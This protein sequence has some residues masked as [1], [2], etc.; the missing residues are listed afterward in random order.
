MSFDPTFYGRDLKVS[1]YQD[2]SATAVR[3]Y[4]VDYDCG[5]I[6]SHFIPVSSGVLET[7]TGYTEQ[8]L[9][10]TDV[11]TF[12]ENQT[13]SPTGIAS[14]SVPVS[15]HTQHASGAWSEGV[16]IATATAL[17]PAPALTA[18]PLVTATFDGVDIRIIEPTD[19]DL[20]GYRV[21]MGTSAGFTPSGTGVPGNGTCV[22]DGSNAAF[23]VA[24]PDNAIRF[25]KIETKDAFGYADVYYT[26]TTVTGSKLNFD[27]AVAETPAITDL[28]TVYGDTVSAAASAAEAADSAAD[29]IAAEAAAIIAQGNATTAASTAT[30]QAGNASVS[31]T[32]AATS[33]T[34]ASGSATTATTQAGL[35]AGSA[36]AAG[37]SATAASTSAGA[38]STSATNASNS[39]TAA[40]S[41]SVSAASSYATARDRVASQFPQVITADLFTAT[42][43]GDP[44]STTNITVTT[45]AAYGPV[46][47]STAGGA[48]LATRGVVEALAGRVY[49]VRSTI[50][51]TTVPG[52]QSPTAIVAVRSLTAAYANVG[53]AQAPSG[54]AGYSTGSTSGTVVTLTRR[55]GSTAPTGG[56]AWN[57]P[58]STIWLRPYVTLNGSGSSTVRVR[59]ITIEDVTDVVASETQASAAATSASNASTSASEAGSSATAASS[60][61]T[62]ASTSAGAASTSASNAASSATTASGHASTA[63]TQAGLAATSATNAGNSATAANTSAGNAST[64]AT[65]AGNSATAAAASSVASSS[66][67]TS[68]RNT[69]A[70]VYPARPDATGTM[71]T[72][73]F[74]GS[75]ESV[76]L[77]TA[78][79]IVSYAGGGYVFQAP[80]VA[81]L[82]MTRGVSPATSSRT[83]KVTAEVLQTVDGGSA[84]VGRLVMRGLDGTYASL[85]AAVGPWVSTPQ[86][87]VTT[88]TYRFAASAT[89]GTTAWTAGSVWLRAYAQANYKSSDLLFNGAGTLQIISLTVDDITDLVAS[90]VQATAAATSATAAATSASAASTSSSAAGSSATAASGSATTASTHASTAGTHATNSSTSATGAAGSA[91]A[92]A[93]SATTAG[94]HA[95]TAG[96]HATT[97]STQASNASASAASASSS[98]SIAASVGHRA[99]NPN[100]GFD[101]YTTASGVPSNWSLWNGS[102]AA[103]AMDRVSDGAGGYAIMLT[104]SASAEHGLQQLTDVGTI[105]ASTYY[106]CE[107]EAEL[108][109]GA[110]TGGGV[111]LNTYNAATST[112]YENLYMSLATVPDASGVTSSSK[113]GRRAWSKLFLSTSNTSVSRAYIYAMSH[114]TGHGVITSANAITFYKCV[115]RP[116]T[117]QEVAAGVALPAL[118]ASVTTTQTT[119][120]T[121]DTSYALARYTLAATTGGGAAILT[122]ASDTYGTVAGI[123]ASKI[124]FGDNTFFDDATDTMRT[125]IGANVRVIAYGAAFGTDSTLTS[126]EGP[127]ATAFA[128]MSRAN[129]YFYTANA[130]P[131]AGGSALAGGQ[132][133][134][135]KT[136]AGTNGSTTGST[137][138][139]ADVVTGSQV[140][141]SFDFSVAY[142]DA[143]STMYGDVLL[144]EGSGGTWATL[145]TVSVG[146]GSSGLEY[147]GG[148]AA[149][150][151]GGSHVAIG[152]RSGSVTYRATFTR[153]SG[154]N[155]HGG[156]YQMSGS[157]SITPPLP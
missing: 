144:E 148:Y 53:G 156:T 37:G 87:T 80:G 123:A 44:A 107:I 57:T 90:E 150:S 103:G 98:A 26:G 109:S 111:Y 49:E 122:L 60:S 61:A 33:A 132:T 78:S 149:E 9:C 129:A 152:T 86:G 35:A 13:G 14:R 116:A 52:G 67:Y 45:D 153:S 75:P 23:S 76:A 96:T 114:W 18:T 92:A 8:L 140:S 139:I 97:A 133:A 142:V 11:L 134:G 102:S 88:L 5:T 55:F 143:D 112:A 101:N 70:L 30:T 99:L 24:I 3:Q 19:T 110:W 145:G 124:Y 147:G 105:A 51:W 41:S 73:A 66:S 17:N 48:Q 68:A 119:V 43:T 6:V 1:W 81:T 28:E 137:S 93:S 84:S 89:T 27:N 34:N 136:F 138:A 72:E 141:F 74:A 82:L 22:Y 62:N 120:A 40:N 21:H 29:A 100:A 46:W 85:G 118:Q 91:T 154:S 83:Y 58:G 65:N 94:T 79:R 113:T 130:T 108:N 4:R 54:S 47:Q 77:P 36:T 15:I 64:S 12:G 104:S 127:S 56:T 50:E 71:F 146:I 115:L 2:P 117:A 95:T 106:V 131:F 157:V 63:S 125:T 151:A 121:L 39:A 38:A 25:F 10:F 155:I 32:N 128:S 135:V 31:A 20:A 7:V 42:Y 16:D 126:W 59:S 69:V